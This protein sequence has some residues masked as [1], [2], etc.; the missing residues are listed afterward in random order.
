MCWSHFN[1]RAPC[2]ARP[3]SLPARRRHANFNP[4]AP[5]GARQCRHPLRSGHRYFNPRAPCG[6]RLD[7]LDLSDLTPE[8]QST[9]PLRGA[10]CCCGFNRRLDAIISIHAPLAGR[11]NER[12]FLVT[13]LIIFQSTRPLRGA[14]LCAVPI[15]PSKTSFQSTRPLRGATRRGAWAGT[16]CRNF[17][18]RAPCGARLSGAIRL[19]TARI[20]IHA[21]LAGRDG[22]TVVGKHRRRHFNPRAPCGA[23]R[24][25]TMDNCCKY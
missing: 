23:R 13:I 19:S 7:V 16:R 8:F 14:T 3:V 1:P 21:P 15:L 12:L 4:R 5:C 20:S 6:A 9:R 2:G 11:D 25:L 10:T 17:N 22:T 24:R 18:P